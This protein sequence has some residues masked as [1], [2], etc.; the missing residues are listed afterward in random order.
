MALIN[1]RLYEALCKLYPGS[2]ITVKH[3]GERADIKLVET[4]KNGRTYS[5]Y[6][7][8]TGGRSGEKY[9]MN[10]PFCGDR[11]RR[12]SVSYLFGS[13]LPG[14][15]WLTRMGLHCFNDTACHRDADNRED[16]A[17]RVRLLIGYGSVLSEE[18]TESDSTYNPEDPREVGSPGV[19]VPL[20]ELSS[21]HPVIQYL[22]GRGFDATAIGEAYGVSYIEFSHLWSLLTGRLLIPFYRSN[23]PHVYMGGWTARAITEVDAG[24][25]YMNSPG[26]L[27][28]YLYGV[29]SAVRCEVPVIVEGPLDRWAVGRPGIALLNCNLGRGRRLRLQAA[30]QSW[31]SSWATQLGR[32]WRPVVV[33]LLD[34]KQK[35]GLAER[36]VRHP[37]EVVRE[38]V[39]EAAMSC[40]AMTGVIPDI[41]PVWLPV[42]T[43]PGFT[44]AEYLAMYLKKYLKG[45]GY[46]RAAEVL[47]RDI[48][49]SSAT[50]PGLSRLCEVS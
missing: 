50:G 6:E 29:Q 14:Q 3:A 2:Q 17:D 40:M 21:N 16:L 47:A 38:A 26:G 22:D 1:P 33:L 30:L 11:K 9:V 28:A 19:C 15:S 35:D 39:S 44:R 48:I 20:Q 43:D 13:Q 32:D 4:V 31:A 18:D 8:V 34:S 36:G 42:F 41:V 25:K 46:E 23:G 49:E 37:M 10:C 45:Q 12:F 5:N 7:F 27:A 24:R